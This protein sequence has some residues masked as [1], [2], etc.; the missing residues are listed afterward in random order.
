M[1]YKVK[2]YSK[3]GIYDLVLTLCSPV[4]EGS[5]YPSK[6][7]LRKN[8][9]NLTPVNGFYGELCIPPF[10]FYDKIND[11]RVW[12]PPEENWDGTQQSRFDLI[13]LHNDYA[14]E[15]DERVVDIWKKDGYNPT[16]YKVSEEARATLKHPLEKSVYRY[17]PYVAVHTICTPRKGY[18]KDDIGFRWVDNK[19]LWLMSKSPD[20]SDEEYILIVNK[21][22]VSYILAVTKGRELKEGDVYYNPMREFTKFAELN[23]IDWD[24]IDDAL[25]INTD[26]AI[27]IGRSPL[28]QIK[29]GD[30]KP[31]EFRIKVSDDHKQI[32]IRRGTK[33]TPMM[34]AKELEWKPVWFDLIVQYA[35]FHKALKQDKD[36]E[37]DLEWIDSVKG[38]R[39]IG[40]VE[41]YQ[42]E[43]ARWFRD[44]LNM[45][46]NPFA[47]VPRPPDSV[48]IHA[49]HRF[50][51]DT[52]FEA[53][54]T[55]TKQYKAIRGKITEKD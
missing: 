22:I 32:Q 48:I 52:V 18:S 19:K 44:N 42:S 1:P 6:S 33:Y 11:K 40:T 47:K 5:H 34:T 21:T 23:G 4:P 30:S 14:D 45:I 38:D 8:I 43:L 31:E 10:S 12:F 25:D 39:E 37:A 51:I 16:G 24:D 15:Y 46:E 17:S 20:I 55:E 53:D 54:W 2:Q 27:I 35:A 28:Y 29:S 7:E 50:R 13:N 3:E 26:E 9:P 49:S 36:I 41:K